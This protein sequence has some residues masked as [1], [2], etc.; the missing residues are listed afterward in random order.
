MS[1]AEGIHSI[2]PAIS[3]SSGGGDGRQAGRLADGRVGRRAGR[4][5]G[6][7]NSG[8]TIHRVA[9]TSGSCKRVL[10]PTHLESAG[11]GVWFGVLSPLDTLESSGPAGW[12]SCWTQPRGARLL[13]ACWQLLGCRCDEQQQQGRH[14]RHQTTLPSCSRSRRS[15]RLHA[16]ASQRPAVRPTAVRRAEQRAEQRAERPAGWQR[17]ASPAV[18][19]W[20]APPRAAPC[21]K[22]SNYCILDTA[23]VLG[24]PGC[25]SCVRTGCTTAV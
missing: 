21:E 18:A 10:R 7:A 25:R 15:P 5:R 8:S 23:P 12:Y 3:N 14:S 2:I 6:G 4:H 16:R 9:A 17:P 19:V 13:L 22:F 20:S 24:L 1:T 11:C